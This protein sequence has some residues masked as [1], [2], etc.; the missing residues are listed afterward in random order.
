MANPSNLYA[1]KIFS[2]HPIAM[3]ALDDQADYLSLIPEE[4]VPVNSK[5]NVFNWTISGGSKTQNTTIANEPLPETFVTTL[6]PNTSGLTNQIVLTSPGIISPLSMNSFQETFSIGAYIFA[7]EPYVTSYEIGYTYDG[8]A[9]PVL[10]SFD[11]QINDRWVLISETFKIPQTVLPIKIVIRINSII[12]PSGTTQLFYINGITFGQWSEEFL[13]SSTGVTGNSLPASVPFTYK[14]ITAK[15]YGLQDLDGYYMINNGS[16]RAKNSSVP[17]VYG[18][19]NVTRILP[20]GGDPSVIIPGQGFLNDSGR[21]RDYTAEM[22]MRIDSKAIVATRVFGPI[23]STDGIYVDGPFIKLKIGNAVGAHPITEW[24][25]PM[26]VDVKVSENTATML[27][28]G[29]EVIS[30]FYSTKD[31][32]LP[33]KTKLVGGVEKDNDWLGFYASDSVFSSVPV[34]DID[35]VAIY[36]YLVPALVAKRRF[37]YGQAIE[38]PESANTAYGGTSVLVDY[39]FADYTSNYSYPDIGRWS[40]GQVENLNISDDALSAPDYSLPEIRFK[41]GFTTQQWY[42]DL[43]EANDTPAT[44][45]FIS[46][47]GKNGHFLFENM[48]IIQQ[49]LRGIFGVFQKIGTSTTK[50]V[51]IKIQDKTNSN[52]LEIYI[53]NNNLVYRLNFSGTSTDLYLEEMTFPLNPFCVGLE[54]EKLSEYFGDQASTFFGNKSRLSLFIGGD[55]DFSKTFLGKIYKVGFSS[56]RNIEKISN[57]FDEKGLLT[58]FNPENYFDDHSED[59]DSVYDAGDDNFDNNPEYEVTLLGG[60]FDSFESIIRL[61]FSTIFSFVASY[62]LIP[63]INFDS[64]SLDIAIDGYWEDY[65][66]LSYFAQYVSD[67][68]NKKYYDLDFI[69]FNIDYPALENFVE[70]FEGVPAHYFTAGNLVRSYVSFQYLKNNSSAK[71]SY[72]TVAPAPKNNVVS[73]RSEWI[74]T[75]YEVVDGTIIYPPRGIRLAD[76][77]IVTHLEWSVPGIITNPLV[78]K[79]LQYASQAFNEKTLNPVG[80]RFG[81]PVFPYLKYG[82]YFDYK[83]KNPYRIYKGSTPYLYL[84]KNSGLEKVG[85]NSALVNRGFSI[86]VNQNLA[87]SYRVIALQ[88]F[89]R[90][91][92]D[93]FPSEPEQIFEIESKDNYIKFFIVANDESGSRARIYG[94]NAKTGNFENGI[95]FYWNGK[96]VREP[97]VTLSDWG[98][99]GISFPDTLNFDSYIGGFRITGSVL[100]NSISQYQSSNLQEIQR[101]TL[102]SWF[103]ADFI[104][105]T[106]PDRY[107]WDFWSEDYNWNGVLVISSSTLTG[108][109][110]SDIYK[111]YTGTNKLII[112]DEVPL[113]FNGYEY[114]TYQ[115]ITWQSRILPAV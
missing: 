95:A 51:L 45:P 19:S 30:I 14:A 99:L 97:V 89:L 69:Q 35:C 76:L 87:Q 106:S 24:Y 77:S 91:G 72:F 103:L 80:T 33:L 58:Y 41:D 15:S 23:D 56:Q 5:S 65:Q 101:Q 85:D 96:I 44:I 109:D 110:P 114:N 28:N 18:S 108:V 82:S 13:S 34:L 43:Y 115:G 36:S 54:I 7:N 11:S 68:F 71:S 66:P 16:L 112:D 62:T 107:D 6:T 21:Y 81:T 105:I 26:L 53:E 25:R 111:V 29:E 22:W 31:L 63:K 75:K 88:L 92:R 10:R 84:T 70:E 4:A 27:I 98:V 9:S 57:L 48:N 104:S 60:D 86:P 32:D 79:K 12:P 47:T 94:L 61:N 102:R 3:W 46:F 93:R 90:Y 100:I 39:S 17:I 113:R 78:I 42:E 20:N 55:N 50:Q 2:E 64:I 1:E 83:S 8:L 67:S 38:F 74:T 37:A 52:N 59:E 73:P 40:Q 49:D